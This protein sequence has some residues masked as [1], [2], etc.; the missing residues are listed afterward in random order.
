MHLSLSFN[1]H[2]IFMLYEFRKKVVHISSGHIQCKGM[3][4]DKSITRNIL[5]NI[6]IYKHF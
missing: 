5:N 4:L 1:C 2:I 6:A 3:F